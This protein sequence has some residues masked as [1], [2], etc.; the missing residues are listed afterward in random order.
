M[1][2]TQHHFAAFPALDSLFQSVSVQDLRWSE[3]SDL[4]V[5]QVGR[6]KYNAFCE[7]IT[8]FIGIEGQRGLERRVLLCPGLSA[9]VRQVYDTC[10]SPY[11]EG[12]TALEAQHVPKQCVHG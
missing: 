3:G 6:E 8:E 2:R 7:C 4:C 10:I 11:Q 1:L 12:G 5:N 9:L